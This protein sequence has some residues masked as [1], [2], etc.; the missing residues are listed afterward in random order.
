MTKASGTIEAVGATF[1]PHQI[2]FWPGV[3][4]VPECC[5][6]PIPPSQKPAGGFDPACG[7]WL[8]VDRGNEVIT[9]FGELIPFSS[10]AEHQLD[11]FLALA[12]RAGEP[13]NCAE[14]SS[15]ANRSASDPASLGPILSRIR[16]LL[17]PAAMNC[18]AKLVGVSKREIRDALI[19]CSPGNLHKGR[20]TCYRLA[21][22]PSRVRFVD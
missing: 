17:R 10:F 2:V 4:L 12:R 11:Y 14:I 21:I 6:P 19:V 18:S 7:S 13:L 1:A 16:S 9:W 20:P 5:E 22:D 8:V 3:L 15:L